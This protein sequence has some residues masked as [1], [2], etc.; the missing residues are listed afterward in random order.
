[1]DEYLNEICFCSNPF[2][3]INRNRA[4]T[5]NF[6]Y[7]RPKRLKVTGFILDIETH[8]TWSGNKYLNSQFAHCFNLVFLS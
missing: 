1:M 6:I 2:Y 5:F 8:L 4:M 3:I 7:S